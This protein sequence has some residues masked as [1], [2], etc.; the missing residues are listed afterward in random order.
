MAGNDG[1]TKVLLHLDG[2]NG[3]TTFTD[4]CAGATAHTFTRT[5]S[6]ANTDTSQAKFG[7]SSLRVNTANGGAHANYISAP[8][9]ADFDFSNGN[10]TIDF[11]VRYNSTADDGTGIMLCCQRG[12]AGGSRAW[13][14]DHLSGNYEFQWSTDGTALTAATWSSAISTGSW[15]HIAIVRNG[16]NID[17]Y[18]NGTQ[19]TRGGSNI[20]TATI[21]NS[22]AALE[23]GSGQ[24]WI[25]LNGWI[26]EFRIS[27]GIARWTANFTPQ[28]DAYDPDFMGQ[29][30]L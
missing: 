29:A 3:G 18:K 13:Q 9:S 15:D 24:G 4:S 22:S 12:T 26:D 14:F 20:S 21:A 30:C 8:D 19:L 11:W 16:T 25:D 28:T 1:Y 23:I 10:F 17:C 27:K 7:A 5:G 6:V 2:S